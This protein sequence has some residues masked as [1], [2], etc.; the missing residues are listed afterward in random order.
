MLKQKYF[1]KVWTNW[2]SYKQIPSILHEA[3]HIGVFYVPVLFDLL[4]KAVKN[5]SRASH[6]RAVF[7]AKLCWRMAENLRWVALPCSH[8]I[9]FKHWVQS[10]H[11]RLWFS[12]KT[13]SCYSTK[14][15]MNS[16]ILILKLNLTWLRN[17][18]IYY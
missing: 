9:T 18:Y 7:D 14:T 1:S 10:K 3:F 15:H 16:M 17:I 2:T 6:V 11:Y 12:T 5:I 4:K 8:F 13:C